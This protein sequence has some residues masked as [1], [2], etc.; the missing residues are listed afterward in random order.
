MPKLS[1]SIDLPQTESLCRCLRKK[2]ATL[3]AYIAASVSKYNIFV[4]IVRAMG[5]LMDDPNKSSCIIQFQQSIPE[6]EIIHGKIDLGH[7]IPCKHFVLSMR[8]LILYQPSRANC[9]SSSLPLTQ[10]NWYSNKIYNQ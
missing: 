7:I 9:G 8:T 3:S 5:R 4:P 6:V 10:S 2:A 1:D